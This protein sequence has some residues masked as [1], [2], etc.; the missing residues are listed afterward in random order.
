MWFL[1]TRYIHGD[2]RLYI[3][4]GM[5]QTLNSTQPRYNPQTQCFTLILGVSLKSA[6]SHFNSYTVFLYSS[7]LSLLLLI[8]EMRAL[9]ATN[10]YQT[11]ANYHNKYCS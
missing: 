5:I 6:L 10:K 11:I 9:T 7:A 4:R 3:I 8:G 1:K 2:S